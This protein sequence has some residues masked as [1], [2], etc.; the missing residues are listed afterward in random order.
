M[1]QMRL[2]V[3]FG[4]IIAFPDNAFVRT[5]DSEPSM[6]KFLKQIFYEVVIFASSKNQACALLEN[7][8][9]EKHDPMSGT[10]PV[11]RIIE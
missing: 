9:L 7:K 8:Y 1:K 3:S 2:F 4:T 5:K 6:L 11:D 10:Q